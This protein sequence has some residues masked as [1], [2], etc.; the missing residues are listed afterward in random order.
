MS[1]PLVPCVHSHTATG[2][3]LRCDVFVTSIIR[4]EITTRTR[5]LLLGEE[6][7]RFEVQ[8]FDDEG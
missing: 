2:L 5:E 3:T 7:E 4:I 1:L 8:T 6:P